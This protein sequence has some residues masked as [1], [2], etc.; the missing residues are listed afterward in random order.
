MCAFACLVDL[1]TGCCQFLPFSHHDIQVSSGPSCHFLNAAAASSD[2]E[3]V[4]A[5]CGGRIW[6]SVGLGDNDFG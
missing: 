5:A 6:T 1:S 3:G 2:Y 4:S